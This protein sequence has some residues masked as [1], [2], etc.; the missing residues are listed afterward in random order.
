MMDLKYF[1]MDLIFKTWQ[2][3]LFGDCINVGWYD[4]QLNAIALQLKW[5]IHNNGFVIYGY[6]LHFQN[7]SIW[8][9]SSIK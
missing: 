9:H 2:F 4:F 6:D 5:T 8:V 7:I 3:L 1:N